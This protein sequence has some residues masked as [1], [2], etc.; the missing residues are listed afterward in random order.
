[1]T[2]SHVAYLA[3]TNPPP[4]PPLNASPGLNMG[5]GQPKLTVP[6]FLH[7]AVCTLRD[8]AFLGCRICP[9][10]PISQQALAYSAENARDAEAVHVPAL[11]V[12]AK[13]RATFL[14][15]SLLMGT[16]RIEICEHVILEWLLSCLLA[17]LAGHHCSDSALTAHCS[18]LDQEHARNNAAHVLD[19]SQIM[20]VLI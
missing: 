19:L 3:P 13:V 12:H 5:L 15:I 10:E 6:G 8:C 11:P 17:H 14:H 4:P 20:V 2:S 9:H 18:D 1:S 16:I 7:R